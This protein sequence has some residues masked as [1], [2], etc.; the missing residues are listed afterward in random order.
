MGRPAFLVDFAAYLAFA[1][2]TATRS[3]LGASDVV[4]PELCLGPERPLAETSGWSSAGEELR[5]EAR[6]DTLASR[7][8]LAWQLGANGSQRTGL[9]VELDYHP[10]ALAFWDASTLAVA[11]LRN[12]ASVLERWDLVA[13]TVTSPT[14]GPPRRVPLSDRLTMRLGPIQ[15]LFAVHKTHAPGPFRDDEA[16]YLALREVLAYR[17]RKHELVRVSLDAVALWPVAHSASTGRGVHLR[18]IRDEFQRFEQ[19]AAGGAFHYALIAP[20]RDE[21][22]VFTDADGDAF[23]DGP[24]DTCRVVSLGEWARLQGTGE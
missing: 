3:F 18:E 23:F 1:L 6:V 8:E 22:L 14:A 7:V 2:V 9:D 10:T 4:P 15:H 5:L 24:S 11:G 19:C 16:S 20:E 13:P 21:V 17:F 12:G